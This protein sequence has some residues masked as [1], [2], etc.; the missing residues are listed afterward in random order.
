MAVG[1]LALWFDPRQVNDPKSSVTLANGQ[2]ILIRKTV[3]EKV[4][5]N[6]AVRSAVVEDVELAK[7]TRNAG[8]CV[9][10]LNGSLLYRTR[11][12]STLGQIRTGWTRILTFLFE[13]KISVILRKIGLFIFFSIAPFVIFLIEVILYS[14]GSNFFSTLI[15]SLSAAVCGLIVA[16]RAAGNR[17]LRTNPLYALLHPVGSLIMVWILSECIGRI[18]FK[19]PSLWR[20]D[21]HS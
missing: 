15:F 1:S 21:L 19:K 13:K 10:F 11:M 6:E 14:T 4:G 17:L 16:V 7:K 20:G 8:F 18:V 9:Q 12:Y 2:F 3:Y 5:G